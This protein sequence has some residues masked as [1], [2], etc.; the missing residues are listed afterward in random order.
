MLGHVADDAR[1]EID[2]SL[3]RMEEL[4]PPATPLDDL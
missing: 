4:F 3:R 2:E 1:D